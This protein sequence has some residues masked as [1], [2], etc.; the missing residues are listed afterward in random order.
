MTDQC[1]HEWRL[2]ELYPDAQ[3]KHYGEALSRRQAE[4]M[5]NE[6]AQQKQEIERL[7]E[8]RR[9]AIEH[10]IEIA[11]SYRCAEDWLFLNGGKEF[12]K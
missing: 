3:C 10:N 4:A 9:A 7:R 1:K 11:K 6:H 12:L 5:L 2:N 8:W